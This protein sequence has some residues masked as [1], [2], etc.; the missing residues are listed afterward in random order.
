MSKDRQRYEIYVN[1]RLL[2]LLHEDEL[3]SLPSDP[4][5]LVTPYQGQAK[6]LFQYL[7]L[8]ENSPRFNKVVLFS[9]DTRSVY[10]DLKN[11]LVYVPAAGGVIENNSGEILMIYRRGFWDLPKG[12]LDQG[13]KFMMAALRECEEETGLH[14]LELK[15]KIGKTF[16]FFRDKNQIRCIKKTQWY[17]LAYAG[18]D[19]PKPQAEE[20]IE[21]CEWVKPQ[22]SL[23][24][25]PVHVNIQLIVNLFLAKD[26]NGAAR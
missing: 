14:G 21:V 23:L 24:K 3:E 22:A 12:K 6:T 10:Q 17:H 4:E 13:E 5:A 20:N 8:L 26:Q 2:M 19:P 18:I 7:D 1:D 16:H 15:S 9:N 25:K 11:L